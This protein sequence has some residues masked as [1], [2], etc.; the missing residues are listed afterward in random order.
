[1]PQLSCQKTECCCLVHAEGAVK[2]WRG[3]WCALPRCGPRL[4]VY[5][6]FGF[7]EVLLALAT[8]SWGNICLDTLPME[9]GIRTSITLLNL[10]WAWCL[11]PPTC[12]QGPRGLW[13]MFP[14]SNPHG[15]R[16][17]GPGP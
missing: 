11:E 5:S 8:W 17:L 2:Q 15:S 3:S 16:A 13:V 10:T 12:P 14:S 7:Q 1:M 6:E 4:W 9:G